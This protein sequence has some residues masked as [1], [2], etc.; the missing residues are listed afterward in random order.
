MSQERQLS[1]LVTKE[2][3]VSRRNSSF[4]FFSLLLVVVIGVCLY[5]FRTVERDIFK[6]G[7]VH[8]QLRWGRIKTLLIDA[9]RDGTIDLKAIYP[10]G[11]EPVSTADSWESHVESSRCDGTFDISVLYDS[12]G[13]VTKV[14]LDK[15]NGSREVTTGGR[16]LEDLILARRGGCLEGR[17]ER[18]SI[19]L[20]DG[21]R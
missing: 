19:S 12:D 20:F 10:D 18:H 1:T 6:V 8:F 15:G 13:N 4:L 17:G 7:E 21:P 9:N 16:A 14:T 5:P 3:E 11:D 2:I